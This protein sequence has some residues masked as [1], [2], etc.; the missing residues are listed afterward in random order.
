MEPPRS[1]S[2]RRRDLLGCPSAKEAVALATSELDSGRYA[3]C[4]VFCGDAERA[5][6]LEGAEWLRVRPLPPGL[7][8]LTNTDIN[9]GSGH[10]AGGSQCGRNRD[11]VDRIRD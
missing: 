3:G 5:V 7:H 10:R 2:P 8:V 4:N 6:V 11:G 1:H 9:G